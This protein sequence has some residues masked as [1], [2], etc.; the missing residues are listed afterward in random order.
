MPDIADSAERIAI[1][2]PRTPRACAGEALGQRLADLAMGSM[3]LDWANLSRRIG[4]GCRARIPKLGEDTI[5]ALELANESQIDWSESVAIESRHGTIELAD[6]WRFL[7]ALTGIDLSHEDRSHY[8]RWRWLEAALIGRLSG[9]P[10]SC[11]EGVLQGSDEMVA[12]G[13]VLRL[14]LFSGD[15][16]ISTHVRADICCWLALL[17]DATWERVM[18]PVERFLMLRHSMVVPFADHTISAGAFDRIVAGDIIFPGYTCFNTAGEGRI[19][20]G[21]LGA[22]VLFQPTALLKV[23]AMENIVE[24]PDHDAALMPD[25]SN[26][27]PASASGGAPAGVDA[28]VLDSLPVTLSFVLGEVHLQIA[29][30]RTMGPGTVL[31]LK[32]VSPSS[33][34]VRAGGRNVGCGEIVDVDGQLGIRITRWIA[35]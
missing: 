13:A 15:H 11:A 14:R 26:E 33:V 24:A 22:R 16:A 29:D 18:L 21:R 31:A 35:A 17:A 1:A 27:L 20:I 4:R 30:L 7:R 25:I 34:S 32:N 12:K 23:I 2:S 10:F 6:G 3:T 28:S 5:L 8:G 9:T 19:R